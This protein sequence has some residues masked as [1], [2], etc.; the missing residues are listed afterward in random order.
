MPKFVTVLWT[1]SICCLLALT[2]QDDRFLPN[3]PMTHK[4]LLRSI[5]SLWRLIFTIRESKIINTQFLSLAFKNVHNLKTSLLLTVYTISEV[6]I[7]YVFQENIFVA[8]LC[9]Q[10]SQFVKQT[11][12]WSQNGY[13]RFLSLMKGTI[14]H[15]TD[16]INVHFLNIKSY[17]KVT[18]LIELQPLTRRIHLV[19]KCWSQ[20]ICT[21]WQF[22]ENYMNIW[23]DW[24]M[25]EMG[26]Y[27]DVKHGWI[28]LGNHSKDNSTITQSFYISLYSM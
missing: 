24:P 11:A 16:T 4:V 26:H 25:P 27:G 10:C 1:G 18:P 8:L 3:S 9:A 20:P 23:L 2:D 13:E 15:H 5:Y 7:Q 28:P 14:K 12:Q 6:A 21:C 22:Y 19:T 17:E